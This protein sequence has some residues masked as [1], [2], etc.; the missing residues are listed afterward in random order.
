MIPIRISKINL[1][2]QKKYVL[3]IADKLSTVYFPQQILDGVYEL[4]IAT[5]VTSARHEEYAKDAFYPSFST[6]NNALETKER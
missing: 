5:L 4:Q 3:L 6:F 1:E 2:V